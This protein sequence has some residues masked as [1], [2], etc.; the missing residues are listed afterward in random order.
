MNFFREFLI[1]LSF[2]TRLPIQL[3]NVT[4][5]EFYNSMLLMPVIGVVIGAALWGF[6]WCVSWI[7]IPELAAIL[8]LI[9]Y[10]WLT[11][12]L[13][14]DGVADTIDAVFSARGHEKTMTIMKDSRLGSFGAIGLILLML[15]MWVG[16]RYTI[17][18]QF[19]AV[20]WLMPVIGRYCAIQTCCFSTYAEG[21]GGLGRRITEI[22][23]GWHVV[24]YLAAIAVV[25]WFVAPI[26]TCAFGITAV[27]NLIMMAD[28][29]RKI[30]GITGDTIGLTIEITQAFFIVVA[31]ILQHL[32]IG[33][34]GM[35]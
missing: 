7:G 2:Y 31:L 26:L 20:L 34:P 3:Q 8:M 11:G 32:G 18:S 23:K 1:G 24:V 4:E 10:I 19:L 5:D 14:Y 15:T 27:L 9:F 28:L 33:V 35:V 21:G 16:Y 12:G 25:S 22:T 13:H 29:K 6:G 17:D 30:G